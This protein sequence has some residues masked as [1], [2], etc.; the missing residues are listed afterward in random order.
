MVKYAN[1]N[2]LHLYQNLY[3]QKRWLLDNLSKVFIQNYDNIISNF[4]NEYPEK[5]SDISKL[6]EA[7]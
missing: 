5:I 2:A 7:S 1:Q 4:K 6:K 3:A